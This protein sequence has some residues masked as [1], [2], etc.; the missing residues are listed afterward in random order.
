MRQIDADEVLKEIE[1]YENGCK[2]LLLDVDPRVIKQ[3]II[4][5][6]TIDQWHYPSRGELPTEGEEVLCKLPHNHYAV[7]KYNTQFEYFG[8]ENTNLTP[9]NIECWQYI[10]P[11]KEEK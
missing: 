11:P 3:H 5:A 1:E 4:F 6:P 8:F 2:M 9:I 10:L 7:G